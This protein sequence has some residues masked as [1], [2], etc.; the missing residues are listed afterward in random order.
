MRRN[1]VSATTRAND[2]LVSRQPMQDGDTR[3]G[4]RVP[5]ATAARPENA[6]GQRVGRARTKP[7][8]LTDLVDAGKTYAARPLASRTRNDAEEAPAPATEPVDEDAPAPVSVPRFKH[9]YPPNKTRVSWRTCVNINGVSTSAGSHATEEAAARA[10][11]AMFLAHG[12]RAVN[13]PGDE[14]ATRAYFRF[15]KMDVL[16]GA[17]GFTSSQETDY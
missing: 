8:R 9:V 3:C 10:I 6:V 11:D 4:G 12:K 1:L 15:R 14:E 17:R 7:E 2:E 5:R 13:F 16:I